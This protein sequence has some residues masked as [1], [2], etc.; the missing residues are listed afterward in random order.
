MN[1]LTLG[2]QISWA[3]F[4]KYFSESQQFLAEGT[5]VLDKNDPATV[6]LNALLLLPQ[7]R[8]LRLHVELKASLNN[9]SLIKLEDDANKLVHGSCEV[10]KYNTNVI[11][12]FSLLS[13]LCRMKTEDLSQQTVVIN[14]AQK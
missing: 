9:V 3:E 1:S 14:P 7:Q 6:F 5:M 8:S 10:M 13:Y 11:K 4:Q 2:P 12:Q